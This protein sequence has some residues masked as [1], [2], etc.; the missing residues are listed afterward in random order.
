MSRPRSPLLILAAVA[1]ATLAVAVG[2][3]TPTGVAVGAGAT[4]TTAAQ[5][6]KGFTRSMRDI[7]IR[8]ALNA[9]F[10]ETDVDLYQQVSFT[11]D[12]G[13]VLL[14][15]AVPK[16]DNRVQAAR[17][18]WNVDGVTEVINEL[19]VDDTTTLT[20]IGRDLWIAA[21]LNGQLLIDDRISS[22]NYSVE[23]VNQVV[24]IMGVARSEDELRRVLNHARD[25]S[26]VRRVV[27][28]TRLP[29]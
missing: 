16:P 10:F 1:A 22:I 15:G 18:A 27:D 6:E 11:V 28:Y 23:V 24:Y 14:T 19:E 4:A 13:R 8:A 17:L 25:I 26:Y 12:Q 5:T 7:S 21:R 9:A 2:G 29:G 20:D 3:C